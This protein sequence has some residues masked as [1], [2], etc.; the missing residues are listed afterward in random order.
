MGREGLPSMRARSQLRGSLRPPDAS[1]TLISE[2][3]FRANLWLADKPRSG[4]LLRRAISAQAALYM[5][6]TQAAPRS[7]PGKVTD[8]LVNFSGLNSLNRRATWREMRGLIPSS[9]V[10]QVPRLA[11]ST[12][13]SIGLTSSAKALFFSSVKPLW[14]TSRKKSASRGIAGPKPVTEPMCGR[15]MN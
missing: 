7:K 2:S 6:G 8:P 3:R 4:L 11:P 12:C 10:N 15:R 5:K 13:V 1:P 14:L 9:R